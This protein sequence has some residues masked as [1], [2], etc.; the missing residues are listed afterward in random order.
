MQQPETHA[1][2]NNV[3]ARKTLLHKELRQQASEMQG[4]KEDVEMVF[5]PEQKHLFLG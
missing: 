1:R 2:K 4:L 3:T 5:N